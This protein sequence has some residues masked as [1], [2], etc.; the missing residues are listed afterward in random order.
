MVY[1][2]QSGRRVEPYAQ[3]GVFNAAEDFE[4][5]TSFVI[6]SK[7]RW[8]WTQLDRVE[9]IDLTGGI[10]ADI[11]EYDD[12]ASGDDE[13]ESSVRFNMR[14]QSV[15]WLNNHVG[16]GASLSYTNRSANRSDRE[17]DRVQIATHWEMAW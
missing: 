17:Y 7:A 10:S 8:R 1:L 16:L 5:Y 13:A 3:I 12:N 4:S 9:R 15:W 14:V 6:G 2:W 11:R